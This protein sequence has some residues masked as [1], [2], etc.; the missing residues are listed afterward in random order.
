M[1]ALKSGLSRETMKG[2]FLFL[3]A[4]RHRHQE[5]IDMINDKLNVLTNRLVL[6]TKE[7]AELVKTAWDYVSID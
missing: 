5:D 3:L 7:Q 4:E 2:F 1:D 6:T